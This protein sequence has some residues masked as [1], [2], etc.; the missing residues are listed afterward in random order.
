[1]KEKLSEDEFIIGVVS[2]GGIEACLE[3]ILKTKK[4]QRVSSKKNEFHKQIQK[5]PSI[6]FY[7]NLKL[8]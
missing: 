8:T 4:K 2:V 3:T 5:D 1:M 7:L 6:L